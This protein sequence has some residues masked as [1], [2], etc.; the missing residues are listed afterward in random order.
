M[1]KLIKNN[2]INLRLYKDLSKISNKLIVEYPHQ[3][4]KGK[5]FL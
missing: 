2:L 4:L 1:D 5:M 3:V